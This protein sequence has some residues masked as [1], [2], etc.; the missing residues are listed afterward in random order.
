MME[1]EGLTPASVPPPQ[2]ETSPLPVSPRTRFLSLRMLS[3]QWKSM[4]LKA[5]KTR[6]VSGLSST[7]GLKWADSG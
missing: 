7:L 2:A 5:T 3:I 4:A 1:Q 6:S